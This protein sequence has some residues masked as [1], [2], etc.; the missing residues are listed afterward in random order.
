MYALTFSP[1]SPVTFSLTTREVDNLLSSHAAEGQ[2]IGWRNGRAILP[3]CDDG[4]QGYVECPFIFGTIADAD[5]REMVKTANRT[6][7]LARS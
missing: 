6:A 5:L 4:T 7:K 1:A 2:S 3:R